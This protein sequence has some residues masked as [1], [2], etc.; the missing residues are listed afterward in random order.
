MHEDFVQFVKDLLIFKRQAHFYRITWLS[1]GRQFH[2]DQVCLISE[3]S[4]HG[5][6]ELE[7][8]RFTRGHLPRTCIIP[9]WRIEPPHD[10]ACRINLLQQRQRLLIFLID[11]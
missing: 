8:R 1:V 3:V 4:R 7:A 9:Y 11:H 10:Q 6:I 2:S 5:P